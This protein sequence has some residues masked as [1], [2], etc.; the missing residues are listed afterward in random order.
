MLDI[1]STKTTE[2][3][4]LTPPDSTDLLIQDV[5]LGK[6]EFAQ[7]ALQ[8]GSSMPTEF[9]LP[10]MISAKLMTTMELVLNATQDMVLITEIVNFP[11]P[12]LP[13]TEDATLGIMEFVRPVQRTGSLIITEFAFP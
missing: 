9:V 1:S 5:K 6:M 7:S 4:N 2:L 11:Q 3:V 13:L 12:Q 10:S 8:D